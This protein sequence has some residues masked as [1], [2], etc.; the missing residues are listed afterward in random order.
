MANLFL[1]LILISAAAQLGWAILAEGQLLA[2]PVI[3][4]M[5]YGAW[6][7]L[8]GLSW[9]KQIRQLPDGHL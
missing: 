1:G 9:A 4:M 8:K 3:P 2:L 6:R 7:N 5:L